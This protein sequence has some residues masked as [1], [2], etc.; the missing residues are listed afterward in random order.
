LDARV[1]NLIQLP[2]L[3]TALEEKKLKGDLEKLVASLDEEDN[4]VV[5]IVKFR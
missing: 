4:P 5:M 3:R 1:A 2:T